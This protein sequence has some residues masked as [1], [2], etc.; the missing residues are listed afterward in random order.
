MLR[1]L[2]W[3]LKTSRANLG[4][5]KIQQGLAFNR[6]QCEMP[7][8]F[9]THEDHQYLSTKTQQDEI[10]K[11]V[12]SV[13]NTSTYST[14]SCTCEELRL[15]DIDKTVVLCGWVQYVRGTMFLI[16][17]DA[18]GQV[19]II[20]PQD[21]NV[22][23]S[24]MNDIT[25]ESVLQVEGIVAKRPEGQV[26]KNT[27]SGEI[28]VH[29]TNLTVLNKADANIPFHI[30]NYSKAKEDL[31]LKHR[32]LDFRFP[33]M[34]HNLRFRSNFLMKA[35]EFL[36]NHRDFVEVE[37]PTLFRRTPG[38]AREFIVPTHEKHQFYSLVQSPQQ[39]KQLL[40][41]GSL[42][43]YF[44]VARCYRD[45]STRPD[46]QPE[47]TQLD[48]ELSFTSRENIMSLIENLFC[49]C[50][51]ISPRIFPRMKYREAMDSYGTD[52]P[53]LRYDCKIKNIDNFL[54]SIDDDSS[55]KAHRILILPNAAEK[56]TRKVIKEY[57]SLAKK[58]FK[59]VNL[60]VVK[61]DNDEVLTK[62][63]PSLN[64]DLFRSE[65]KLNADDVIVVA[66]GNEHD[67][68]ACLGYI[69]TVHHKTAMSN[70]NRQ[71]LDFEN[72]KSFNVFWV[73]DFP[74]FIIDE[75]GNMESAHHPFTQPHPEDGHLLETK[76]LEVRGLHYDLVLNGNE[77]GG[78]SIRIHSTQLQECMLHLLNIDPASLQHML[79]AFK[80]GCPPHG[81]I[82]LGI[83]RLMSILCG[84]ETIRDVIAFP[85]GFGGKDHLSGAP[86]DISEQEKLYYHLR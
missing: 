48:I 23:K 44:Q 66:S 26:R 7:V 11:S 37:T 85:K 72:P 27:P 75:D 60:S 19:Q 32:Y 6:I 80:Y 41:V 16:L 67:V 38:G 78:G 20:V 18:Y 4:F 55:N 57:Q 86:C 33:E 62:I 28:E 50:L 59:T 82:A 10:K 70:L 83:D 63:I 51:N 8:R 47:F 69:R 15:S 73:V 52:K 49:F 9:L 46:R 43:R 81:G 25:L 22:M 56:M 64:L 65:E 34:Q 71:P 29:A 77:I 14:R 24:L 35:R 68:L 58:M 13:S 36:I 5:D 54:R 3:S 21:N 84:T 42:D 76:P 40:M 2:V 45:E 31:R 39:L 74:L 30:R 61:A 17:R 12:E 79:D 53:D 1:R